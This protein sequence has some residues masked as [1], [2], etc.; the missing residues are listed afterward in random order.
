VSGAGR[1]AVVDYGIGNL[2]SAHKA[3][4][5]LGADAVLTPDPTVV[6]GAAGVVVPGVGNFAACVRA[7]RAS[8][9]EAPVRTAVADG[10]PVLGVCVGLQMLFD[11]SDEDDGREPGL[12]VVAGRVRRL[13][14]RERLPQIGWN[15]VEV[16]SRS[17]LFAGL[18]DAPWMYFVHSY[19]P[20][21]DDD[22]IVTGWCTYGTRF[23]C[24]IERD[25][26]WAVQFHPEKSGT[27]GLRLLDNFVRACAP[28]GTAH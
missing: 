20:V 5:H 1:I 22:S 17:R 14:D 8:G 19:A 4:V 7:L 11:A 26:V 6:D 15:T 27:N 23:A 12:G 25:N 2:A 9:L 3:L 16:A 21:P 10:R 24:A 13:S 28:V 18:G